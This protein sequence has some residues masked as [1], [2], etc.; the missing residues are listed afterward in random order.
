MTNG[1]L[2]LVLGQFLAFTVVLSRISGLVMTAPVFGS[3]DTPMRVRGLLAVAIALIITPMHGGMSAA[4]PQTVIDYLVVI[5]A[6]ILV[7]IVLGLG[8]QVI[9]TG[10]QLAGHLI[11][12]LGGMQLADVVSPGLDISMPVF[13]QLL[14]FV[15]LAVFVT[16]GGHRQVIGALLE[17]YRHVPAGAA[18]FPQGV[19]ESLGNLMSQSFSL[20]IR[21]AAP[22][23]TALLLATL[24]LGIISRT[25]PQLNVLVLGFGINTFVTLGTLALSLGVIGWLFQEQIEPMIDLV[26]SGWQTPS[27]SPG[28]G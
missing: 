20:G 1:M 17:T 21:T 15:A 2:Q 3:T 18:N 9:F 10:A 7:G 25:L 16:M 8:V 5:A 4:A 26:L 27:P 19:S 12:Q 24:L 11:S 23:M 13:S 22:T 6:E 28:P 14:Y